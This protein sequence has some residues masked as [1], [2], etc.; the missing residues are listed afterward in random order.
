MHIHIYIYLIVYYIH[1]IDTDVDVIIG[2][3]GV[4]RLVDNF[5]TTVG[6]CID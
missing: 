1:L 4:L 6:S 5:L 2:I 3:N